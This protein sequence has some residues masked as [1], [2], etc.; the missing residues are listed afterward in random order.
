VSNVTEVLEPI[1]LGSGPAPPHPPGGGGRSRERA[2]VSLI[3]P[4]RAIWRKTTYRNCDTLRYMI[5]RTC[6]GEFDGA[7][8]RRYCSVECKRRSRHTEESPREVVCGWCGE[9]F[10]SR[11]PKAKY[12]SMRCGNA[13][14]YAENPRQKAYPGLTPQ[15]VA[16][17]AVWRALRDGDLLKPDKCSECDRGDRR[18]DAH[19][20]D[21]ERP[22]AVEWLCRSCHMRRHRAA[23]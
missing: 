7:K 3:S 16:H 11:N 23:A 13:G 18:I 17:M 9:R 5:C 15:R 4:L 19:H 12:C 1:E 2:R 21:Y 20:E 6:G 14:R 8:Q 10:Q 22:L